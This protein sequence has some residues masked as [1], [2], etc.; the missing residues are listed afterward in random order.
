[1]QPE[2]IEDIYPLSPLQQGLLFHTLETPGSGVYLQQL[3][4]LLHGDLGQSFYYQTPVLE[5]YLQRLPNSLMLAFVAMGLSL[6]IGIP[7]GIMASV[8]VGRFWDG[9]GKMFSLLGLSLPSFLVGL[10]SEEHTS[11]LQSHSFIST[12]CRT[13]CCSPLSR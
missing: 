11:E 10:R 3:S 1:M 7:A 8:Q 13:R 4:C 6:L 2:N 12:G 5:L 9:F